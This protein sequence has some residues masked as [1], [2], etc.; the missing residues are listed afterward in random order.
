MQLLPLLAARCSR[1]GV[2][3]DALCIAKSDYAL[4]HSELHEFVQIELKTMSEVPVLVLLCFSLHKTH[5]AAWVWR[6]V[7]H[8][9]RLDQF[10]DLRKTIPACG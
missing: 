9:P 8:L 1:F 5:F 7:H 6:H 10:I 2:A 4:L 3:E